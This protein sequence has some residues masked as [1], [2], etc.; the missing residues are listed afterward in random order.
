MKNSIKINACKAKHRTEKPEDLSSADR[1]E[2]QRLIDSLKALK[3]LIRDF[4]DL[5]IKHGRQVIKHR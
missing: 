2:A 1:V 5:I 3:E 4:R